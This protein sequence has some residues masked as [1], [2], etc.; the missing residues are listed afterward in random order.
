MIDLHELRINIA[1]I[2]ARQENAGISFQPAALLQDL[3][4]KGHTEAN[5]CR[6][7]LVDQARLARRAHF[8][9]LIE[10]LH[11]NRALKKNRTTVF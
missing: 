5:L 8:L 2:P 7:R 9:L 1:S 3:I 10:A 4:E 6:A 11:K